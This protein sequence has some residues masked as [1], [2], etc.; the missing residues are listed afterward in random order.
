MEKERG[1]NSREAAACAGGP[2]ELVRFSL[3]A[4]RV[5][6]DLGRIVAPGGETSLEP[7]TI[8]VLLHLARRPGQVVGADEL[9]QA[10][11]RGRP[12][13]DNPVYRCIAQLR[14]ALGDDPRAPAYIATVPTRGYRLIAPVEPLDEEPPRAPPPAA[15]EAP[16][17]PSPPIPAPARRTRRTAAA[18]LV[19]LLAVVA[20]LAWYRWPGA[21]VESKPAIRTTL[22]VLP[23]RA[24][25]EDEADA[26]LAQGLTDLFRDRL[27]QA[28]GLLVISGRSSAD[29]GPDARAAG[30]RLHARFLLDGR[31]E[32]SGGRLRVQ[33]RLVDTTSSTA[34]WTATL[35]RPEADAGGIRDELFRQVTAAL[36]VPLAPG[37]DVGPPVRLD[38]YEAYTRGRH[39]LDRANG[40][41]AAAAV[42]W[43]R[44]ATTL[45]PGFARAYLGLG[46]AL[47]WGVDDDPTP[48]QQA[49][50]AFERALALNPALGEAWIEQ[51]QLAQDPATRES[52][53]RKGLALAPNYG[54]G[55]ASYAW[56]LH[57]SGRAGEAIDV[58]ERAR[59]LDPLDPG[60]YLAQAFFV[61][62][63]RSDV[64]EHDRLVEEALKINP[65]S[66]PVLYQLA[67]SKWEYSGRFA[68]AA[69]LIE[70]AI[71]N[72]PQSM[73]VRTLARDIYLD[74]GDPDA[75]TAVLGPAA[76]PDAAME[77]AQYKGEQA[78]AAELL[79]GM[80]PAH[81]PD[82]GPRAAKAQAVR[83]AALAAGQPGEA[84][85]LLQA[86]H[87]AH[88]GSPPMY[89]RGFVP[90]YAHALALAGDAGQAH[91]LARSLLQVLDVHDVG[92][93][94]DWFCRE[95]A[96]AFAVL[97]DDE[98]ALQ[99]LKHAVDHGQTYRWWYLAEHDPLY[100]HLR[101]DPR[102]QALDRL[103]KARRDEQRALLE[104]MRRE[105]DVPDALRRRERAP[106]A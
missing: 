52:L 20:A 96:D 47:M 22:A 8:A 46:Q 70:R 58:I 82:I 48:G 16:T 91:Q 27:A 36:H 73:E 14:R 51:A 12:M 65:S 83:D 30:E 80:P 64:A 105:G 19:A 9:I 103:A 100:A 75:A 31:A 50:R 21:G 32:R 66:S 10:V 78:K 26:L 86:V 7:K 37:A 44:R 53:Y 2:S 93:A 71:A 45:D 67:Y 49:T 76:P 79:R 81:W 41:D 62:V 102:F 6:A 5:D 40:T 28:P 1:D 11:W 63:V 101:G 56:F 97:G 68:E 61:M 77:I 72:E 4:C 42:E 92:R 29:P 34:V 39:L 57:R 25:T 74:L 84:V 15:P 33:A 88:Q 35:E 23:L 87:A 94:S 59:R 69:R 98:R 18:A 24:P 104:A 106:S 60:P 43:F 89:H 38:A 13:G 3:G 55:Y 90:V 99:Q 85:R 17:E 95:R 54:P